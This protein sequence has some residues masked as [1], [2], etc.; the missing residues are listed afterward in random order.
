MNNLAPIVL[1]VYNR[2]HHTMRTVNSLLANEQAKHSDLIIYADGAR[3]EQDQDSVNKVRQWLANLSGFRSIKIVER[4]QNIGLAGNIIAGVTQV[5]KQYGS[6]IVLEDDLV[7]SPYFLQYMNEN[8]LRFAHHDQVGSLHGYV[9]PTTSPLPEAFFLRGGDCWGWATWQRAWQHFEA[10]G[11]KLFNQL[12]STGLAQPFDFDGLAGNLAMLKDQIAGRNNSWAI[13][14]H[15][16]LYLLNK[17]TLY[18]GKSLVQNIGTDQ[19]GQHCVA[20]TSYDTT[21]STLPIQVPH[22]ISYA[23]SAAGLEAY[24]SFFQ[25]L[26][27]SLLRRVIRKAK[28][29]VAPVLGSA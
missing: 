20:T 27:P 14:W 28:R 12:F 9:I 10:D 1:F 16:S 5:C 19:S 11:E 26:R 6:V 22:D 2:L 13:R 3:R 21:L 29:V 17:L 23:E 25:A 18:P 7:L 4:Q 24:R 8:L 15:A